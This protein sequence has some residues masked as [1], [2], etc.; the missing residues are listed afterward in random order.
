MKN[1]GQT[2]RTLFEEFQTEGSPYYAVEKPLWK[3]LLVITQEAVVHR[4]ANL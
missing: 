1:R 2:V 4:E 3:S